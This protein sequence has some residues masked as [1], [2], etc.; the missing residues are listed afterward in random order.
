[1]SASITQLV[2]TV[3]NARMDSMEIRLKEKKMTASHVRVNLDPAVF[4]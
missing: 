3:T 2:T 1:M 4:R